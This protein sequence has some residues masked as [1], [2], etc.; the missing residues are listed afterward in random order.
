[1]ILY[2]LVVRVLV[3]DFLFVQIAKF[4][5]HHNKTFVF[6]LCGSYVCENHPKELAELL[7]YV[8]ILFGFVEEYKTLEKHVDLPALANKHSESEE[9]NIVQNLPRIMAA[10]HR[11][12]ALNCPSVEL[13]R[14]SLS[15]GS[16]NVSPETDDGS[17]NNSHYFDNSEAL[18]EDDGETT[19]DS[20]ITNS[21]KDIIKSGTQPQ[22]STTTASS[23]SPLYQQPNKS[24]E[25]RNSVTLD[26]V[27]Y[28]L[29]KVIL[30]T[31]GPDPLLY[32]C[33][34]GPVCE[35]VIAPLDPSIVV[36]T[37][38]AGDSFVG[39]FLASLCRGKDLRECVDGGAWAA[40]QILQ[41]KG[42]T[43]PSH[44]ADFL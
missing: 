37:T 26:D 1:M 40:R 32:V 25:R 19:T 22:T 43:L 30:M 27:S 23:T 36:D 2:L 20:C 38:G 21:L 34:D 31:K 6:N 42:V 10:V 8:D 41:Q 28:S 29:G 3:L 44:S 14:C 4:A 7:P 12:G 17:D 9:N 24:V 15:N 39:G 33:N 16:N 18:N 11:P 35:K 5:R 13:H